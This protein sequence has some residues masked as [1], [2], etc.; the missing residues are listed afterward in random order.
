MSF[1]SM[2]VRQLRS[3]CVSN[4]IAGYSKYTKKAELVAF[5]QSLQSKPLAELQQDVESVLTTIEE[6]AM[7]VVEAVKSD[8]EQVAIAIVGRYHSIRTALSTKQGCL[9]LLILALSYAVMALLYIPNVLTAVFRL[10]RK[11]FSVFSG[12]CQDAIDSG[13]IVKGWCQQIAEV[14]VMGVAILPVYCPQTAV[15]LLQAW[16]LLG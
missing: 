14:D 13:A 16:G 4:Q 1:S 3:Y 11:V 9:T 2:T 10:T 5:L 7:Q 8:R 6:T 12:L 15:E